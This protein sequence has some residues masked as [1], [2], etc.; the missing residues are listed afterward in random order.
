M[1]QRGYSPGV[2]FR[3]GVA[4]IIYADNISAYGS[5]NLILMILDTH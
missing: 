5:N 3:L 2:L 1:L 4:V